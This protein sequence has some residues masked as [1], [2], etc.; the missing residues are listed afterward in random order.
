V[1][2]LHEGQTEYWLLM[3]AARI[4]GFK[5]EEKGVRLVEYA[6]VGLE[7]LIKL[8]DAF[9]IAWHCLFDGDTAGQNN[10]KKASTL[11]NGRSAKAH[12]SM[13]TDPDIEH[14]ICNSGYG[15]IYEQNVNQQKANQITTTVGHAD[16]W[17]QVLTAQ[18]KNFKV[19]CIL[20]V[21]SQ[22]SKRRAQSG[23]RFCARA[24][25]DN[26]PVGGHINVADR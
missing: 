1:W 4:A 23:A 11:L 26:D 10:A 7:P 2:L 16:Y 19:P 22:M 6:H 8:A 3:E 25:G 13:L 9:G 21:V 20:K 12:M 24:P 17:S 18:P 14:L 15:A 5:L